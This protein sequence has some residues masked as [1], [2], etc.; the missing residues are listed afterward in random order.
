MLDRA[1]ALSIHTSLYALGSH[2]QVLL[3]RMRTLPFEKN[4]GRNIV[5]IIQRQNMEM[6]MGDIEA[7]GQHANLLRLIHRFDDSSH[8]FDHE[9]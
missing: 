9:H 8:P 3:R 1:F 7:C 5:G 6:R 4:F 2:S